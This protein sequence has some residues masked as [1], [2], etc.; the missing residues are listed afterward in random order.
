MS[1][2]ESGSPF[3]RR[4]AAAAALAAALLAPA[5]SLEAQGG[6]P[7]PP[8]LP[9]HRN[10]L[11]TNILGIPF[12]LFSLEYER[13]TA[14]PGL[15]VGL[16]GSHFTGDIEDDDGSGDDRNSWVSG[17]LHYYPS[18]RAFRG[19]SIGLTA[20]V[21]SARGDACDFSDVFGNCAGP[22]A[23]RRSQ[24]GA[25][26]GVLANYDRIIGSR[27]R[28]RLGI[29]VGAKRILRDVR[30]RDVLDQV[31]PDGRFVVGLTF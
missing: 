12:G 14:V 17:K 4:R 23:E 7:P 24:T 30:D 29:G 2:P 19:F 21:H 11:A 31:Y 10:S 22:R 20:G 15:T 5:S 13:A 16:G 6:A 18:E 27:E 9:T 28:F 1:M 8:P 25:T 3:A 26:L